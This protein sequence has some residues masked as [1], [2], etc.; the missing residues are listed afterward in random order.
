MK[1]IDFHTKKYQITFHVKDET[2]IS[3][4]S[5]MHAF[6]ANVCARVQKCVQRV[7]ARVKDCECVSN[8]HLPISY[9]ETCSIL[10]VLTRKIF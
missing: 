1:L 3:E 10:G 6:H 5:V 2:N 8:Y 4:L 7:R 9:K